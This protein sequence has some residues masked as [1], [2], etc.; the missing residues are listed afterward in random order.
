MSQ[1]QTVSIKIQ[2][3]SVP[4]QI[5][6]KIGDQTILLR[7]RSPQTTNRRIFVFVHDDPMI[8]RLHLPHIS[9]QL[10]I[11]KNHNLLLTIKHIYP[12]I[13]F[14]LGS[15]SHVTKIIV[16]RQLY[17]QKL[18]T[19][20]GRVSRKEIKKEKKE[21][22]SRYLFSFIQVTSRLE[23]RN[24]EHARELASRRRLNFEFVD[25]TSMSEGGE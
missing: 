13:D 1:S 20:P 6:Q 16:A 24:V 14:T 5:L 18:I 12:R 25:I 2:L 3:T 15:L 17:S 21:K 8:V 10:F 9:L 23:G 19:P 22:M 4:I 11:D 7:P